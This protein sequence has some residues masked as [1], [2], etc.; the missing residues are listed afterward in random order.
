MAAQI[1]VLSML[2]CSQL[3]NNKYDTVCSI[4]LMLTN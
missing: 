4:I 2:C 1:Y 3:G